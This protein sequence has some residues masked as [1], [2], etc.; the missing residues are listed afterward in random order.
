MGEL[1][2][3]FTDT[4]GRQWTVAVNAWT[5][6]RVYENAN[7]L[8]T[9]LTDNDFRVLSE[10]YSDPLLLVSVLWWI[11]EDQALEAGVSQQEFAEAFSG[12]V[13]GVARDCLLEGITNFFDDPD[14]RESLRLAIQAIT[15][16]GN[17]VAARAAK[18]ATEQTEKMD[19]DSLANNIIDSFLNSP[20]SPASNP[21]NSRSAN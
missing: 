13:I 8:L 20:R 12:D 5:V 7:C 11:C 6:R 21:G 18:M 1:L 9:S 14:R 19:V 3:T 2:K 15:R 4:E 17:R 16:L 10:L